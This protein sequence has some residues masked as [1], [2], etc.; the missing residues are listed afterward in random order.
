MSV[1][2]AGKTAELVVEGQV[3]V[4]RFAGVTPLSLH[5]LL[6]P[7]VT[8]VRVTGSRVVPGTRFVAATG[9]GKNDSKRKSGV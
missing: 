2:E 8:G 1:A 7:A 9:S 4:T 5:V 3:K 6:A